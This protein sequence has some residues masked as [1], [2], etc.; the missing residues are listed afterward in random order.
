MAADSAQGVIAR[1]MPDWIRS[2]ALVLSGA[3]LA[4]ALVAT[5]LWAETSRKAVPNADPYAYGYERFCDQP[6]L[7]APGGRLTYGLRVPTGRCLHQ[8]WLCRSQTGSCPV[9]AGYAITRRDGE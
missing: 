4:L 9:P 3:V 5:L 7:G 2:L 6:E 8:A 1:P